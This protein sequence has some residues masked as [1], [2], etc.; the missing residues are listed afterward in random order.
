MHELI[1][2]SPQ[3]AA[4]QSFL[5]SQ[6]HL[7]T[8]I[9]LEAAQRVHELTL[10]GLSSGNRIGEIITEIMRSGDVSKSQATRIARTETARTAS[11]L[12]QVRSKSVG[13][14]GYIWRTVRDSRVRELHKHLEG[15]YITWNKPPIAGPNGVR[16]HAGQIYNCRCYMEPVLSDFTTDSVPKRFRAF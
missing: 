3:G 4:L 5:A 1:W 14:K 2:E 7:I 9:P 10:Q 12:T 11:G 13:S 8:S 16:A 15:K 6:E